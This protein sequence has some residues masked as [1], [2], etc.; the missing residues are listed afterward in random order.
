[1]KRSSLRAEFLRGLSNSSGSSR[2]A[3]H[4]GRVGKCYWSALAA[5]TFISVCT[6]PISQAS[7]PIIATAATSSSPPEVVPLPPAPTVFVFHG[8]TGGPQFDVR[9]GQFIRWLDGRGSPDAICE[10]YIR[11]R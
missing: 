1:V 8:G 11:D 3:S 4:M 2:G 7:T 5:L 10:E 6:V 9:T